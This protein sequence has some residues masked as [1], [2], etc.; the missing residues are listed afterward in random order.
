MYFSF[1]VRIRRSDANGRARKKPLRGRV[2]PCSRTKKKKSNRTFCCCF[3]DSIY[4]FY[5]STESLTSFSFFFFLT[6]CVFFYSSRAFGVRCSRC[7]D[8]HYHPYP[9]FLPRIMEQYR[10]RTKFQKK[11]ITTVSPPR[12]MYKVRARECACVSVRLLLAVENWQCRLAD[13]R[14]SFLKGR[15]VTQV[16]TSVDRHP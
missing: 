13:V 3:T 12:P 16:R 11:K 4:S 7:Y 15:G 14:L 8:Y 9:P 2:P 5:L 6:P 10:R 1:V